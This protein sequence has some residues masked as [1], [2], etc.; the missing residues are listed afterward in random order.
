MLEQA[1][2]R[3][4]QRVGLTVAIERLGNHRTAGLPVVPAQGGQ[5]GPLGDGRVSRRGARG[6]GGGAAG[7]RLAGGAR[8][9]ERRSVASQGPPLVP[10]K[11][12]GWQGKLPKCGL[13]ALWGYYYN[14]WLK[15]LPSNRDI[16]K[17]FWAHKQFLITVAL[18]VYIYIF[19]YTFTIP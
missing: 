15:I 14:T 19:G 10:A 2:L 5:G 4:D 3:P 12:N 1:P 6:G 16:H 8:R 11:N 13:H 9:C 17:P 7:G 18:C